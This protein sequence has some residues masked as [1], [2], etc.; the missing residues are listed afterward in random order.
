MELTTSALLIFCLSLAL[1]A[2]LYGSVGQAGASGF[3][4][5]LALFSFA[6][7]IIKPTALVL[8]VLVS[9]VVALRFARSGHFSWPLLRPFLIA[10]M[11]A[12]LVGG[13]LTLPPGVFNTLLGILLLV[14]GAP[15][16]L[17]KV[18][19]PTKV[20]SPPLILALL[21]GGVIGLV[22]GLTGMG[23]GVLLAPLLIYCQWAK[24]QAT[25][26]A[27]AVF[28]LLNSIMALLG[29]LSVVDQLPPHLA[30]F[31]LAAVIGGVIGARLGSSYLSAATIHRILG[32]TLLIAGIK[33]VW[34]A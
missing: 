21:A 19:T 13:Y 2:M 18:P 27:S 24:A 5:L 17:R 29:H 6:P 34:P 33:L 23:G 30:W 7:D 4:A 25:A 28:I 10:S 8:N 32:G 11:P 15:F 26:A 20:V 3:V 9:S 12:A 22:S 16:F 31:A 1:I 14:A